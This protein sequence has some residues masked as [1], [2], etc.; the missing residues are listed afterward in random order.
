M[1]VRATTGFV[2]HVGGGGDV[3]WVNSRMHIEVFN[4]VVDASDL[5]DD[6]DGAVLAVVEELNDIGSI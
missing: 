3:G 6:D 2:W 5:E 1:R 4:I